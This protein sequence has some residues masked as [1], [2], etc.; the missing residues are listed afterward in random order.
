MCGADATV[1]DQIDPLTSVYSRRG[2]ES[3]MFNGIDK[4]VGAAAGGVVE[5]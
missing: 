5:P 2:G 3:M 1:C 4:G